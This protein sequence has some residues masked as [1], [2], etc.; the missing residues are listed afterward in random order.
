MSEKKTSDIVLKVQ[1]DAHKV[2]ETIHW[3]AT[4]NQVLNRPANA[5]MLSVWDPNEQNTLRVDLW[6]KEMT[7]DDM[8]KFIHQSIFMMADTLQKATG[9]ILMAET[10]R[11]FGQYYGEKLG[12]V[13]PPQ[14][15]A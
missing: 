15:E 5:M 6:T 9:E 2:P 14:E 3:D 1:L 8:K 4:D 10:M 7:V 13:D 12:L 11:D